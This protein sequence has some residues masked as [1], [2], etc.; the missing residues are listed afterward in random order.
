MTDFFTAAAE[1]LERRAE[2]Q[3]TESD[4]FGKPL[5]NLGSGR[6]YERVDEDGRLI[7]SLVFEA[8][9]GGRLVYRIIGVSAANLL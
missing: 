1:Q 8:P 4:E 5:N 6:S 9:G 2:Q 3:A 7:S